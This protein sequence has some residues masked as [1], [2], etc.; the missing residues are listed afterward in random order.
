MALEEIK[1]E[2]MEDAIATISGIARHQAEFT[3]DDLRR[4]MREAASPHWY[5]GAF[6]EA[7]RQGI[8]AA[9]GNKAS[10]TKTRN[11][12]RH[13]IWVSRIEGDAA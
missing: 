7:K 3:A 13:Q 12:G 2:W 8:I 11:Y 6:A 4:E 9:I 1:A 10:T 5:G